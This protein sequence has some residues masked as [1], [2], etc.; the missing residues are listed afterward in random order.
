MVKFQS[1]KAL[2]HAACFSR[3]ALGRDEREGV[4][5]EAHA[6]GS[7]RTSRSQRIGRFRHC[8]HCAFPNRHTL[9]STLPHER[10]E[11]V[12]WLQRALADC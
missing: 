8:L 9:L 12:E 2:R 4:T 11:S 10:E 7:K 3:G 6:A 5:A 1:R